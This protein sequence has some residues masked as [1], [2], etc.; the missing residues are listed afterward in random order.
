MAPEKKGKL[1]FTNRVAAIQSR[2]INSTFTYKLLINIPKL[3]ELFGCGRGF[4]HKALD[5]SR[6]E[7]GVLLLHYPAMPHFKY[8]A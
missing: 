1:T 6:L 7:P 5:V 4:V 3:K 8:D 2:T